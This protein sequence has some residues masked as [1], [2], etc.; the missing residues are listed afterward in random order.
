MD[1]PDILGVSS[2]SGPICNDD[3]LDGASTIS[4]IWPEG[5][6]HGDDGR[7]SCNCATPVAGLLYEWAPDPDGGGLSPNCT[8]Q[9]FGLNPEPAR[10]GGA[11]DPSRCEGGANDDAGGE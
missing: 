8:F 11:H 10:D 2:V 1:T 6:H 9:N 5:R 7:L 3:T 4:L